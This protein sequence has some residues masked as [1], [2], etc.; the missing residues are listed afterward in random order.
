[1][2]VKLNISLKKDGK[3]TILKLNTLLK[4]KIE[5][6]KLKEEKAMQRMA[7]QRKNKD[8]QILGV[9]KA[10]QW[11][12]CFNHDRKERAIVCN[13]RIFRGLENFKSGNLYFILF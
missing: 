4:K 6:N 13:F 3:I 1:M 9:K 11:I 8:G 10:G 2:I 7:E 12:R 5:N